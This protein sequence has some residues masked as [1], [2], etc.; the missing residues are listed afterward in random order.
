MDELIKT[1]EFAELLRCSRGAI[2]K[3]RKTRP[4]FP[5]GAKIGRDRLYRKV[6]ALAYRDRMMAAAGPSEQPT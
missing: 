6:D 3:W 2:A 1:K 5:Q 4:G